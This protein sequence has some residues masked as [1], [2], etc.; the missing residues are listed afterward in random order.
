M[1]VHNG[2]RPF[3]CDFADC[4]NCFSSFNSLIEHKKRHANERP[5]IC[6][7]CS[8]KFM[9]S[10]TLNAHLKTECIGQER[11]PHA[12][13]S[14]LQKRSFHQTSGFFNQDR[15]HKSFAHCANLM[16][17]PKQR[18]HQQSFELRGEPHPAHIQQSFSFGDSNKENKP[19]SFRV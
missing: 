8:L 5:F 13:M 6:G 18:V 11:N 14:Y 7:Y 9:K 4:D 16:E 10:S 19:C 2:Q 3:K 12:A 1:R 17:V 15:L